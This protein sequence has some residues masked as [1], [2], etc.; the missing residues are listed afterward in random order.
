VIRAASLGSD[1][2]LHCGNCTVHALW[3][4]ADSYGGKWCER[5]GKEARIRDAKTSLY[6]CWNLSRFNWQATVSSCEL[7]HHVQWPSSYQHSSLEPSVP[8]F[9]GPCLV[10]SGIGTASATSPA[11]L[12]QHGVSS[13]S[14][15]DS[16][17]ADSS[18]TSATPP[19][20]MV[21]SPFTVNHLRSSTH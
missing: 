14:S 12:P 1:V 3:K 7:H 21:P 15:D 18:T 2:R 4:P 6:S 5:V 17:G 10:A 19:R 16:T 8:S 13:G 9:S 20:N 11:L